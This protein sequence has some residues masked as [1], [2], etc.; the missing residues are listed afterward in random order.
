MPAQSL[1]EFKELLHMPALRIILGQGRDLRELGGAQKSLVMVISLAYAAAL[2][3]FVVE[4]LGL[5]FE[6]IR[7]NG[8]RVAGPALGKSGGRNFTPALDTIG[9]SRLG[10]E[11]IE[12]PLLADV[13]E[14]FLAIVFLVGED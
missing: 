1:V 2:N 4:G 3:V 9:V 14:E 7:L 8:R 5:G 10:A 12:D 13:G 6:M 11:Q